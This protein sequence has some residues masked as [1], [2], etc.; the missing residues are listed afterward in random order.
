MKFNKVHI[1]YYMLI[2]V[3]STIILPRSKLCQLVRLKSDSKDSGMEI[4]TSIT[5]KEQHIIILRTRSEQN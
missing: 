4:L 3:K 2:V 5:N 1:H